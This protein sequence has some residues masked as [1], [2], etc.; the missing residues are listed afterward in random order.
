MVERSRVKQL[1]HVLTE[2]TLRQV[3]H[4]KGLESFDEKF[5][6][7]ILGNTLQIDEVKYD[8]RNSPYLPSA[9]VG[10]D[11]VVREV[12]GEDSP[13]YPG[14]TLHT[15][16]VRQDDP[17]LCGPRG[18]LQQPPEQTHDVSFEP[19]LEV[20]RLFSVVVFVNNLETNSDVDYIVTA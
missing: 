19:G 20:V 13:H 8:F 4:H 17:V 6:L 12:P 10:L 16:L 18:Q 1:V 15:G 9:F 2:S 14:D 11:D 5:I 3:L 7:G